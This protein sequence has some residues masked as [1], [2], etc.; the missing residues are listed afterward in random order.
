MNSSASLLSYKP[1]QLEDGTFTCFFFLFPPI[2][3]L[4]NLDGVRVGGGALSLDDVIA[5]GER[6]GETTVCADARLIVGLV[7]V[8]VGA[9]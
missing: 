8:V 2:D 1:K 5:L 6:V 9:G 3:A 4:I 7:R